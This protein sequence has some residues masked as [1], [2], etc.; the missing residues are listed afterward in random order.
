MEDGSNGSPPQTPQLIKE[1]KR[2][3][4]AAKHKEKEA[5]RPAVYPPSTIAVS[6]EEQVDKQIGELCRPLMS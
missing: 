3:D 2:E 5:K 1:E 6:Y 4:S